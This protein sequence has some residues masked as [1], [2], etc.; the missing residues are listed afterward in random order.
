MTVMEPAEVC[1]FPTP[2]L[3]KAGVPAHGEQVEFHLEDS[4][5]LRLQCAHTGRLGILLKCRFW[6]SS[7]GWGLR[8]CIFDWHPE[9]CQCQGL[10]ALK[11]HFEQ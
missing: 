10:L 9:L 3:S 7:L 8:F 4:G 11:P 1:N 2:K 5:D 6:F